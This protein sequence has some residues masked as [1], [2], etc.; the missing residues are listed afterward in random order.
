MSHAL[1]SHQRITGEQFV[2]IACEVSGRRYG[3]TA[4]PRRMLSLLGIIASIVRE[5][6]EMLYQFEYDH[7][8]DS[9]LERAFSL[10]AT[11]YREGLAAMLGSGTTQTVAR[12]ELA[13]TAAHPS[14]RQER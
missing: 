3:L 6:V 10:T 5:N 4:A 8:F 1:T 9:K 12:R 2:R 11:S 13:R 7:R 14:L